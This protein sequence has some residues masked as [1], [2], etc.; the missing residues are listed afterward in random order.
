V[1]WSYPRDEDA[2]E[3]LSE[4][5]PEP[6]EIVLTKTVGG[7]FTGTILDRVLRHMGVQHL[8]ICGFVTDECVETTL[9]DAL[10]HG[11]L[12]AVIRDATTAYAEEDHAHTIGKFGGYGMAPTSDAVVGTFR[13][14]SK[15]LSP[16]ACADQGDG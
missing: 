4:V 6:G 2:A 7:A 8:F 9:R 15:R 14:F 3:F 5:A 12:A 11:Y 16:A 13:R 1:G 10:D